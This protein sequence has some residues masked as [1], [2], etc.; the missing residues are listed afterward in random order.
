MMALLENKQKL[1]TTL[2]LHFCSHLMCDQPILYEN[3]WKEKMAGGK[4]QV[5]FRCPAK[6]AGY[7]PLFFNVSK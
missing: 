3:L 7:T 1:I 4:K 6:V 5:T 2:Y